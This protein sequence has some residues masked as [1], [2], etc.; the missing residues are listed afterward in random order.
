M[1]GSHGLTILV[2]VKWY[3]KQKYGHG[4]NKRASSM[5]LLEQEIIQAKR[6]ECRKNILKRTRKDANIGKEMYMIRKST[7]CIVPDLREQG[8]SRI[9]KSTCS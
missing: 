4:I 5:Y 1:A 6:R 7:Q 8:R 3:L 9:G 2:T